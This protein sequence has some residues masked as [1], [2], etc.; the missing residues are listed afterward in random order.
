MRRDVVA[1][2]SADVAQA[3]PYYLAQELKHDAELIF[4]PYNYLV[5]R[6]SRRAL[7]IDLRDAV[8]IFDEAH[9]LVRCRWMPLHG[10]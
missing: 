8:V 1:M 10:W 2:E 5:D 3:C 9:N 4:L 7:N 6:S